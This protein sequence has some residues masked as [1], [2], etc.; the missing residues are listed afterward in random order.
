MHVL[1]DQ[2]LQVVP[3]QTLS[4]DLHYTNFSCS[5]STLAEDTGATKVRPVLNWMKQ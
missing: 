5:A 4:A 2:R 3:T 1:L